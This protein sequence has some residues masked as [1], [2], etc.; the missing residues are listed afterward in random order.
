VCPSFPVAAGIG[1][2]QPPV[3]A[4]GR[5]FWSDGRSG[6]T[7]L[8]GCLPDPRG[9]RCDAYSL[10]L[11]PRRRG[12]L[13]SD[14]ASLAWVEPGFLFGLCEIDAATGACPAGNIVAP[15]ALLSSPA[16]SGGLLAWV[17][18]ER[19][20]RGDF[21][22]QLQLCEVPADGGACA[23][24]RVADGVNDTVPRLSGS[25]LVWDGRI[26]TEQGDVFYCEFD[27]VRQRCP[28]QRLTAQMARQAAATIDGDWVVWEDERTGAT[29]IFGIELPALARLRDR[30]L[31]AGTRLQI[32][33]RVRSPAAPQRR[34][35]LTLAAEAVGEPGL[36]ALG[37]VFV[38]LGGGRGTFSWRPGPDQVG[39][40]AIT[41]SATTPAGLVTRQTIRVEVLAADMPRGRR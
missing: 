9:G 22:S 36:E 24:I 30:T 38:D 2:S 14:G 26:G 4:R 18:L 23:P 40:H 27:R 28:V 3:S 6:V 39:Q 20:G 33:I 25:R 12:F 1:V 31:P 13:R 10:Q 37:A 16:V 11:D 41:F 5:I 17:S 34:A 35:E 32:P 19:V 21:R 29:E 8:R 7:D 15:D